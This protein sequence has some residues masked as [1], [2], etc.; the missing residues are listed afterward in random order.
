MSALL[1][2][3]LVLIFL[4]CLGFLYPEGMWSNAIRLVNVILA[5]LL[6]MNYFEP[7][8]RKLDQWQPSYTYCWDFLALWMVFGGSFVVLRA[9][10]DQ[11]SRVKVRFLKIADQIGSG[12][13]AA[14]IGWLMIAFTLTTLHTAP[15]AENFFF[16]AFQPLEPMFLGT[17][18][19]LAWLSLVRSQSVG[20]FSCL[21]TNVFSPKG[22]FVSNYTERR[23]GVEKHIA[24]NGTPRL[25]EDQKP[26]IPG[27]EAA[28]PPEKKAEKKAGAKQ[29]KKAEKKPPPLGPRK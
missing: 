4:A 21:Q 10:T 11:I 29:E 19:D 2:L 28:A 12:V 23:R 6:A 1:T 13:L 18:P 20:A 22:D 24:A 7:L 26:V 15:L 17:S 25:R 8:A 16:G 3:I 9:V 5:G 14:A 27:R